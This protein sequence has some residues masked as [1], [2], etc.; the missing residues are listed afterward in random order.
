MVRTMSSCIHSRVSSGWCFARLPRSAALI[1]GVV[2]CGGCSDGEEGVLN[3]DF[4]L[5]QQFFGDGSDFD[6]PLA[7]GTNAT[8]DV[9]I[10]DPRINDPHGDLKFVSSIPDVFR[11]VSATLRNA[12]SNVDEREYSLR[13]V[14]VAEGSVELRVERTDGTLVDS[15][16]IRVSDPA[17]LAFDAGAS[18]RDGVLRLLAGDAVEF[19][20]TVRN[21]TG[22]ELHVYLDVMWTADP[23]TLL[24]LSTCAPDSGLSCERT[25]SLMR[26]DGYAVALAS[27]TGVL[28]G[29][30]GALMT[31]VRVEV[32]P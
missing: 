12:A 32:A 25:S 29:Q 13:V 19:S 28:R 7:S 2:L 26:E 3:N 4:I 15:L 30:I 18:T 14:G 9:N 22:D 24:G 20:S 11:I 8:I 1:A 31:E 21:A 27:G 16:A 17:V 5:D 6:R 10:L 23:E